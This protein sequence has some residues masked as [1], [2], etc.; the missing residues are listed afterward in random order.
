MGLG[1]GLV[2]TM[3]ITNNLLLKEYRKQKKFF[4]TRN[5]SRKLAEELIEKLNIETPGA[6]HPVRLLSEEI[7]RRC[8][9]AGSEASPPTDYDSLSH[10][11]IGRSF[12]P[13]GI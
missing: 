11:G 1:M 9:W 12:L 8:C 6:S 7:F 2:S 3:D 4:I 5:N 13:S 10:P